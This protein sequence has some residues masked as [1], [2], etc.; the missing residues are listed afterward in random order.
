MLAGSSVL[1]EFNVDGKSYSLTASLDDRKA[2]LL[3]LSKARAIIANGVHD[4]S[5][6]KRA[7][8]EK[9]ASENKQ[10]S[11]SISGLSS[12]VSSASVASLERD[13]GGMTVFDPVTSEKPEKKLVEDRKV[14]YAISLLLYSYFTKVVGEQMPKPE[15]NCAQGI[16]RLVANSKDWTVVKKTNTK[17]AERGESLSALVGMLSTVYNKEAQ[18]LC[19]DELDFDSEADALFAGFFK[20][21]SFGKLGDALAAFP[22]EKMSEA[23]KRI[24][25]DSAYA[26]ELEKLLYLKLFAMSGYSPYPQPDLIAETYPQYKIPKPRGNFGGKKKRKL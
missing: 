12:F 4:F 21:K 22:K 16:V 18:M 17:I 15:G 10:A 6:A 23:A 1:F 8:V 11:A 3:V 20:R 24:V 2:A 14:Q 13:L 9:F 26:P 5:P 19:K 25:F 7:L